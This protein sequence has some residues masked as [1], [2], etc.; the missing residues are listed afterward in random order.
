MR[1]LR[2]WSAYASKDAPQPSHT[3][4]TEGPLCTQLVHLH[5]MLVS[6]FLGLCDSLRP[7][8]LLHLDGSSLQDYLT[9]ID[10]LEM[11]HGQVFC[12]PFAWQALASL[13]PVV[14]F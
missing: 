12:L 8:L 9:E 10:E 5:N 4:L 11:V 1:H 7:K 13:L 3:H 14:V 6:L 2:R